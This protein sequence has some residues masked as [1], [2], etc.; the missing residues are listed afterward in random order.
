MA[1]VGWKEKSQAASATVIWDVDTGPASRDEPPGPHQ[2][3]STLPAM[4]HCCRKAAFALLLARQRAMLPPGSPLLDGRYI[5]AQWA[6]PLQASALSQHVKQAADAA[7]R[8]GRPAPAYIVKPDGGSQGDGITIETDPCR[9]GASFG[10]A[11][12]ERVV[13]QYVSQPLLRDG[14][15]FDLRLYVLVTSVAPLRAFLYHEG[16]AR[17]AVDPYAAPSRENM[18]NVHMHLTNYSLNKNAAGFKRSDAGDGGNDGSKRAVSSLLAALEAEG[19]VADAEQLWKDLGALVGRALAVLQPSLALARAAGASQPRF[20]LLGFDVL[21]DAKA[22]PWLIEIND[23]PSLRTDAAYDEPGQYSINGLNSVPSP[24]DEAV[25]VPMLADS[26]RLVAELCAQR[27]LPTRPRPT[28]SGGVCGTNF[29]AVSLEPAE[30]E[31]L[32]LLRR[33]AR[34]FEVHAPAASRREAASSALP[35][36]QDPLAVP[37]LRWRGAMPF[38]TFLEAGGLLAR[39]GGGQQGTRLH[40]H[41]ADLIVLSVCGKGG[42]MDVHDFGEACAKVARRISPASTAHAHELLSALL[43]AHYGEAEAADSRNHHKP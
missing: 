27:R 35:A 4:A 24:V 2:L 31:S 23:H 32:S 5:P 17:F 25:K 14:L 16:L 7:R 33:L 30:E 20:K 36:G 42:S 15:K 1:L 19:K 43:D 37:G 12:G 29:F 40:R 3:V 28:D 26:L 8:A 9:P 22:Q 41:D 34:L 6:L 13:Q 10:G 18:R 38:N 21:L 11:S 39:A